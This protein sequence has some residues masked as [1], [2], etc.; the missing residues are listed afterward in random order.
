MAINR[1]RSINGDFFEDDK[2]A[3]V[4]RDARLFFVG[5]WPR[6]DRTGVIEDNPR[7]LKSLI[8]PYDTDVNPDM[9]TSWID[10]LT[11]CVDGEGETFWPMIIRM[12]LN[13]KKLLFAPKF[14]SHQSPH[15]R[16]Q[17]LHNIDTIGLNKTLSD[18][19]DLQIEI[20]PKPVQGQTEPVQSQGLNGLWFV[21]NGLWFYK[22]QALRNVENSVE[23]NDNKSQEENLKTL[24]KL[25]HD[26]IKAV[27]S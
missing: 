3:R 20:E 5:L 19:F 17:Y 12:R 10:E 13:K 9:I 23:K 21:V 2:V 6:M 11:C 27:R 18:Y 22:A 16:E 1:M 26:S 15:C 7:L 14:S 4:S 8:F 24:K 25:A